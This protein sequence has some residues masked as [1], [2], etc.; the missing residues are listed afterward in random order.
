LNL[1]YLGQAQAETQQTDSAE[2]ALKLKTQLEHFANFT[3]D[4]NQTFGLKQKQNRQKSNFFS[5]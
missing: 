3:A 2:L 5:V 1:S 4:C